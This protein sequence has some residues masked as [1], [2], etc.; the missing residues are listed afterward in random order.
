MQELT[1]KYIQS[2]FDYKD[3]EL[4]WKNNRANGKIK[5]GSKAG[6]LST[7]KYYQVSLNHKKYKNHRLI[8]LYHKGYLPK[9][10]DHIDRNKQN[11]KIENLREA[12]HGQN[13]SNSKK[14]I[15]KS[16]IYKDVCWYKITQKWIS[17]ITTNKKVINL[18]YFINELDAALA[19]NKAAIKYFGEYA[20]LNDVGD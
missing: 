20:K 11:N 5:S 16:S 9:Y 19:Y 13:R 1:Q 8:F 7:S 14:N 6:S 3:G 15:N 12:T 17:Q 4:Y 18:G 10:V 2:L